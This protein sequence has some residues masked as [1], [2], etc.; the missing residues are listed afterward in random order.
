MLSRRV[1]SLIHHCIGRRAILSA[2]MS[3]SNRSLSRLHHLSLWQLIGVHQLSKEEESQ[4]TDAE[5]TRED[6]DKINRFSSLHNKVKILDAEV[7]ARKVS[8][9]IQ[10]IVHV[11]AHQP[12]QQHNTISKDDAETSTVLII[13][14]RTSGPQRPINRARTRP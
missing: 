6:Q 1:V 11:N 7:E 14:E 12:C 10:S 4:T 13:P 3:S 8:L 9:H 5:V 2:S